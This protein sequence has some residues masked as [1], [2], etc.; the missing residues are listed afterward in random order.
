MMIR[1]NNEPVVQISSDNDTEEEYDSDDFDSTGNF[2]EDSDPEFGSQQF[3]DRQ[4]IFNA[5]DYDDDDE[6]ESVHNNFSV[7]DSFVLSNNFSVVRVIYIPRR[8]TFK[9]ILER[10]LEMCLNKPKHAAAA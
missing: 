6:E 7:A 10:E 8:L 4:L 5:Y 3:S 2:R 1:I 9:E